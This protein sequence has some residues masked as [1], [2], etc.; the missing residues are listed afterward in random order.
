[1][2]TK[3]CT[4]CKLDLPK[5]KDY[6]L[7]KS[8]RKNY[9]WE[10][11]EIYRSNC[12]KCWYEKT[13]EQRILKRCKE[14]NINREDWDIFKKENILKNPIF[15][16]KDERL[17]GLNRPLRARIL[18]KIRE[19]NY[20]FTTIENYYEECSENKSNCQRIYNYNTKSKLTKEIIKETLPDYYVSATMG[21]SVKQ[22]PKEFI[23]TKRLIIKL[24][25]ELKTIKK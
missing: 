4:S 23:D 18:R 3:T 5:T 1:M 9:K 15:K 21:K 13:A 12:K 7:L 10:I 16:L 19:D 8:K 14:L 17:K 6:F 25:R 22:V 20:I 24:K 11:K 2:E